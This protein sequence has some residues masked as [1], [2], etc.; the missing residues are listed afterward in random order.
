[1]RVDAPDADSVGL[2]GD[3]FFTQPSSIAPDFSHDARLGD[4]WMPGDVAMPLMTGPP[5]P[6]SRADD[7]IWEI[8]FA[9]PAG[10]YSYGF[11]IGECSVALVC[12]SVPDPANPPVLADAEGASEQLLSQLQIPVDES[13]PTYDASFELP[14][15]DPAQR[16]SVTVVTYPGATA[17]QS[18]PIG[19]Y[20]PAGYDPERSEPYPLLVLSHGR[21]GNETSWF[22]EGAAADILDR[23]I[24]QGTIP[25]VVAVTTLFTGLVADEADIDGVAAAYAA[26]LASGVLPFVESTYHVAATGEGRAFG[27]LSMGGAMGLHLLRTQPELFSWYGIWSAAA[28]LDSPT[29]APLTDAELVALAH[30]NG[31]HMGTGRQD[32][33]ANIGALSMA[34]AE[35]FAQQGLPVTQHDIDGGHTWQVW[36]KE[37]GDY[38]RTVAFA[39]DGG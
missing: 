35:L 9:L 26:E 22:S 37:L 25:P 13:R 33:L 32:Y 18:R 14:V 21:G 27:G 11:V 5:A 19:V 8:T 38:V 1:M 29:P 2:V 4:Y 30:V 17:G 20:L 6:L 24:A 36:R 16:G 10:V 12:P 31:V 3:V 34:R 39:T 7:G 28:D 23:A 15:E